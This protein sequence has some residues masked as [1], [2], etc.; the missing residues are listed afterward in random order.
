MKTDLDVF[1]TFESIYTGGSCILAKGGHLLTSSTTEI[2]S[3]TFGGPDTLCLDANGNEI[4]SNDTRK[5]MENGK[6]FSQVLLSLNENN[7]GNGEMEISCFAIKDKQ[8]NT[9]TLVVA[10]Q[11]CLLQIYHV[12]S[13]KSENDMRAVLFKQFK[14]HE[15]PVLT[16]D[17]DP[18]GTLIATG[19]A[20]STIKVWD[21]E[22]GHATHNFKGHSG[23]VSVVKFHPD[24]KKLLLASGSDDCKVR[25]WDL[26]KK[27][28]LAVLDGH[29]SVIR[30]LS[31]TMDG[32]FLFSAGRDKM[33]S[34]WNLQ[35]YSLEMS[36][37][38]FESIEAIQVVQFGPVE[39]LC[40]AGEKGLLKFWATQDGQLIHEQVK[41]IEPSF[42]ISQLL[43]IFVLLLIP[44]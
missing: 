41:D 7:N 15:A 36:Q 26:R 40:T 30:G 1:S 33:F 23:I 16:M 5:I 14:V 29:V 38:I 22:K 21:V 13:E 44:R 18:T 35:D 27:N 4:P 28:C 9:F 25:V 2:F 31:Y 19:S 20:D 6:S 34:K 37:P 42:E 10:L 11:N 8:K 17:F 12:D 3:T 43:Y 32:A 24:P 39:A